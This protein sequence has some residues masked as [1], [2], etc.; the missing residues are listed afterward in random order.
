MD[1][2][3]PEAWVKGTYDAE[4]ATVTIAPTYMGKIGETPHFFGAYGES[5]AA[6]L[7]LDYD[8]TSKQYEFNGWVQLY[9]GL[10]ITLPS[11]GISTLAADR[12]QK[13]NGAWYT[14]GG[15]RVAQPTQKGLYIHNGRKVVIK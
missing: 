8:A 2:D 1:K 12:L 11:D 7:V 4:Q 10:T 9:K 5:G 15:Q 14:L 6:D 13:S 3:L